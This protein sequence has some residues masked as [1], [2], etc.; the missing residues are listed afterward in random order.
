MLR[1]TAKDCDNIESILS[2]WKHECT[3]VIAD[4]FINDEDTSWFLGALHSTVKDILGES[5]E[6]ALPEEPHWVSFMLDPDEMYA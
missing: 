6:A 2:L 5:Y 3:R 4:R 1:V